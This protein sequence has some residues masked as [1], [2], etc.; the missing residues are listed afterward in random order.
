[1][2][3]YPL[4]WQQVA[5]LSTTVQWTNPPTASCGQ[6]EKPY[7]RNHETRTGRKL[8]GSGYRLAQIQQ[9]NKRPPESISPRHP[10]KI[11]CPYRQ[12]QVQAYKLPRQQLTSAELAH[13]KKNSKA[14]SSKIQVL[15]NPYQRPGNDALGG[16]QPKLTPKW[17]VP[18]YVKERSGRISFILENLNSA[19]IRHEYHVDS[20]KLFLLKTCYLR[21]SSDLSLPMY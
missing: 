4:T 2:S 11:L 10:R 18:F 15:S 16:E 8:Q 17:R 9:L 7:E 21:T 19:K 13:V 1:V 14:I 6:S 3:T 20:L 5:H 12:N